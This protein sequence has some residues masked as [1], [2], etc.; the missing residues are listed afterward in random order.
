M[1]LDLTPVAGDPG[2]RRILSQAVQN[3]RLQISIG[4]LQSA[5]FPAMKKPA[6]RRVSG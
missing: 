4:L 3:E 6:S 1:K 5:E 2:R